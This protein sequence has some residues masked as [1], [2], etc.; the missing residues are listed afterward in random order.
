MDYTY[1]S[2]GFKILS[3]KN[4]QDRCLA[5]KVICKINEI[6]DFM[7]KKFDVFQPLKRNYSPS[8]ISEVIDVWMNDKMNQE[9]LKEE[10]AEGLLLMKASSRSK[11]S[12]MVTWKNENTIHF[13]FFSFSVNTEYLKQKNN[14][15][16]FLDLSKEFIHLLEPVQGEIVN[17]SFPGAFKPLDL[18]IRHPE[19]QW[20]NFF[21]K[22]YIDLFGKEKLLSAPAYRVESLGSNVIAI[23]TTDN[24]FEPIPD[25][26]REKIKRYLGENA[27]VWNGK[28]AWDYNKKTDN[29]A[30][31]FNFSEV[32]FDKNKPIIEPQIWKRKKNNE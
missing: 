18:T 15:D 23:Q 24:V 22:P 6:E 10:Y 7:P 4:F 9:C 16:K 30:P 32:F 12:Y 19:L 26:V 11:A 27:F 8:D 17:E 3:L 5:S 31:H 2:I 21:G 29:I 1:P 13:N 14:L 20:M 28:R 25:T